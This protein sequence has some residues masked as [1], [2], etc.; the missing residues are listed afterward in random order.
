MFTDQ[1]LIDF[2]QKLDLLKSNF[3]KDKEFGFDLMPSQF[4]LRIR[5]LNSQTY[6]TRCQAYF[7]YHLDYEITPSSLDCGDFKDSLG[8]DI[9]FKCSF[10]DTENQ[11][12]NCKQIRLWQ[13]LDKYI[14]LS[15]D[16]ADYYDIKF[17]CY[18]LKKTE[19]I[20]ECKLLNAIPVA[21]TKDRYNEYSSL[22]LSI[23]IGSEAHQR[24]E[25]KY[26]NKKFD[27]N[28]IVSKSINRISN[29][30]DKES[31]IK[32]QEEIIKTFDIQK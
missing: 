3:R 19:M 14:I 15:I 29:I 5:H 17:N 22:G 7:C 11:T 8:Y 6:G 2:Y 32:R 25:E 26:L 12:I 23:K 9:E 21:N 18:E 28:K 30:K 20:E 10:Q 13:E 4:F 1:E 24:W 27:I 31:I 16:Y